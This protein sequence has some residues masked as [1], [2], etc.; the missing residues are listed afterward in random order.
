[1]EKLGKSLQQ[2]GLTLS[3]PV[4]TSPLHEEFACPACQ[5]FHFVYPLL[6]SGKP[7]FTRVVPCT[8]Q[9]ER[10]ESDRRQRMME[11]CHLPE[12]RQDRTFDSFDTYTPDLKAALAAAREVADP[13]G[14]LKWLTIMAKVDRGK[15]H[16]AYAIC[17]EWLKRGIPARYVFVPDLLD[18]LRQGYDRQDDHSF[19]NVMQFYKTVPLLVLDDL[20]TEK[21]SP[22][23]LEKLT[24]I[25]NNRAESA[26]HLVVTTNSSLDNLPGDTLHRI[27]SRLRREQFGK[28]VSIEDAGEYAVHN[29]RCIYGTN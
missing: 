16:L 22:W 1:M 19:A 25:I 23:V 28:V 11:Y 29:R 18:E 14:H 20:G 5:D 9:G 15:S 17:N 26:L 2:M 3:R 10:I 24:T 7:D 6:E 12:D 27:G 4:S 8:C 13:E 21:P